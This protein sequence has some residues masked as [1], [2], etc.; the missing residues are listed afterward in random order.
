MS[1]IPE[2]KEYKNN[3]GEVSVDSCKFFWEMKCV[4]Q[5]IDTEPRL[6]HCSR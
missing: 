5:E 6:G 3:H 4:E 1:V 2:T